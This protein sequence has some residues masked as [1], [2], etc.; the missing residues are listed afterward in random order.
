[1]AYEWDPRRA[2]RARII[3]FAAALAITA[4]VAVLLA[5]APRLKICAN[6][7]VGYN[8]FG[9]YRKHL[10]FLNRLPDLIDQLTRTYAAMKTTHLS[11]CDPLM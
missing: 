7:A 2:R 4:P 1:M 10:G 8:N 11:A 6:M 5:A 3:R 9:G